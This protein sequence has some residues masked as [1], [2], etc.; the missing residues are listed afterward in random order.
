MSQKKTRV[1]LSFKPRSYQTVAHQNRKRFSVLVWH[2]RS[3][4]T[5][6]A[7][8]ELI[9]AALNIK[10]KDGRFAYIAPFYGQAKSVAWNYLKKFASEIPGVQVREGELSIV[11]TNGAVIR[12][13]GADNPDSLRGLYF[14]GVVMDEVADMK[15]DMWGAIMRPA[16]T[17]RQ[18]WALFIGTPKGLNLFSELYYSA[19]KDPDWYANMKRVGDT[20]SIA[21]EEVERA[22]KEMNPNQ[23][24]QEF[25]CDFSA[26]VSNA[27]IPLDL[28]LAAVAKK[29][30]Q[31]DYYYAPKILGVDVARFGDDRS[32]LFPRQGVQAFKPDV[33]RHLDN[34]QLANT[35]AGYIVSWKPDAV[36]IDEVGNGSGVVDRLRQLG[37]GQIIGVQSGGKATDAL[38]SNLRVQMWSKMSE[39]IKAGAS[40]P[41]FPGLLED[42]CAP[43]F[44]FGDNGKMHLE[45]TDDIKKR[46]LPSPDL[47]SALAFSFAA[48]VYKRD[49]SQPEFKSENTNKCQTEY[50]V[51]A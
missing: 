23:F 29:F 47:G 34:M 16:L 5:V 43:T 42:L 13:F 21:V 46:G 9:L 25:E 22:R 26:A 18:G 8:M 14:D 3:G 7:I 44:W 39:W 38:M 28:A 35:V 27:L 4:K 6:F 31:H 24:A 2:R 32:V 10:L 1:E 51:L 15:P 48:P 49:I 30:T 37:F 50:D 11:F 17:D 20:N 41:D 40:L 12:L 36:F 19:V 33:Y 45:S